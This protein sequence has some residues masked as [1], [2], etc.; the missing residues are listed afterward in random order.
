MPTR[1]RKIPRAS[2]LRASRG[3]GRPA[4]AEADG[5]RRGLLEAAERLFAVQGFAGVTVRAIADAAGVNPAMIHYYFGDK[6]GLHQAV[7]E[8]ALQP[9]F[10]RLRS[11]LESPESERGDIGVLVSIYVRAVAARPWIPALLVREVLAE[12]GPFRE[13][14]VRE[15]APRGAG[16]L[17]RAIEHEQAAGRLRADLHP[18]LAALSLVSMSLFPFLALPIATEVFGLQLDGA[19]L[20]RLIEHTEQ[21]FLHGAEA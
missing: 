3:A 18:K 21:M 1:R 13:R 5:V 7:L 16:T 4:G 2:G 9:L 20:E 10:D 15:I 19:D 14:F 12:E 6:Q 17:V 8:N 11:W